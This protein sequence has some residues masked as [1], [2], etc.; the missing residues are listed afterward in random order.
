MRFVLAAL[1]GGIVMFCWGA[2]SHM[3]L[4][5]EADMIK[6]MPNEEAVSGVLKPA[7]TS[8]GVYVM[9]G[10]DMTRKPTDEEMNS[11][12][13]KYHAGPTAMLFY[14]PEGADVF[15]PHQFGI[16]FGA[17]LAAALFGSLIL[18]FA[19][20]GFVRGVIISTL[21]GVAGWSAIL[22]PYWNW[23]RFPFEFVRADLIDQVAGWFLAGLV[24]A[25]LLRRRAVP[26]S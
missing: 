13:A 19:A 8:P 24:M 15:S 7:I 18:L 9:P 21:I 25:A 5:L 3:V 20:T 14:H 6:P 16:Q 2:F 17:D 4:N 10:I 22:I 1:L 11:W 26:M 23:Y 12:M